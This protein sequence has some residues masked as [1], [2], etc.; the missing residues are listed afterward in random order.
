MID[1]RLLE[2][3]SVH[4]KLELLLSEVTETAT[5]EAGL[6]SDASVNDITSRKRDSHPAI[7]RHTPLKRLRTSLPGNI[8]SQ[9]R[10]DEKRQ[11]QRF[12]VLHVNRH[13]VS[14]Y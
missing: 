9:P 3:R 12:N 14:R 7:L 4:L 10:K 5:S 11:F 6:R 2:A 1:G 8:R 13:A